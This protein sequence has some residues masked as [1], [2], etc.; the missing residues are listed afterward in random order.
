[1]CMG[2][3]VSR[4]AVEAARP[5]TELADAGSPALE[6]REVPGL[7]LADWIVAEESDDR[8]VLL[9]ALP[10]P[11]DLGAGD[12]RDWE[13][14]VISTEL[15]KADPDDSD[16]ML[17]QWSSCALTLPLDGLESALGTLDPENLPNAESTA[18]SLLVTE[19]ACNS[20]EDAEGRVEV[21]ELVETE[22]TVE[23]V[24][25]TRPRAG[26]HTCPSNPATPFTL[27]LAAPLGD[28]QLLNA[29]V[30]PSRT[31]AVPLG[32]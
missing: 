3:E 4:D 8:V 7:E 22:T 30:L 19:F 21:V 29:G 6:G 23:V 17:N 9:R 14:I 2:T 24:L 25:A 15:P 18:V 1:L 32:G 20:G 27:E 28:R 5:A 10:E 11:E 26:A 31:I 16:W 12:I 13:L